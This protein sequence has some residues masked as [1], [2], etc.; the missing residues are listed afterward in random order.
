MHI[1]LRSLGFVASFLSMAALAGCATQSPAAAEATDLLSADRMSHW[2]LA[3][4]Y[5]KSKPWTLADGVY[6]GYGSIV[7]YDEVFTDYVLDADFL[8]ND[9]EG[10]IHVRS[11]GS[12]R[13]SW[14]VGYELDIDWAGDLREGHIHFPVKPK[15]YAGEGRFEPGKWHHVRIEAVGP[16]VTVQLDGRPVLSFK[17]NGYRSGQICLQGESNGVRYRNIRVTRLAPAK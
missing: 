5:E 11:D 7:C 3:A 17:D 16:H 9:A 14:E 13:R 2:H 15:P 6:H 4:G 10:G 8:F 12:A 1:A